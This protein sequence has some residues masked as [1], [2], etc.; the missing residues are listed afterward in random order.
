MV[1]WVGKPTVDGMGL[2]LKFFI[3][4]KPSLKHDALLEL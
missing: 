1:F 3:L 4:G 2:N